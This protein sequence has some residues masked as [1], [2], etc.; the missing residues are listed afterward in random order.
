MRWG[1]RCLGDWRFGADQ[2]LL[3]GVNTYLSQNNMNVALRVPAMTSL[4]KTEM[5]QDDAK[6][7]YHHSTATFNPVNLG[8]SW[9]QLIFECLQQKD[10]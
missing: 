9:D 6:C 10:V 5:R 2:G 1:D 3:S 8:Q 4:R 7:Q